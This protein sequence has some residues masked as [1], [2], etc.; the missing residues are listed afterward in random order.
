M[1]IEYDF[2]DEEEAVKALIEKGIPKDMISY[3]V[4]TEEEPC[5]FNAEGELSFD[6]TFEFSFTIA[7]QLFHKIRRTGQDCYLTRNW[8]DGEEVDMDYDVIA[9][10]NDA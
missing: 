9:D 6:G 2:A 4:R 8:G 7:L 5:F 10:S 3:S 1:G